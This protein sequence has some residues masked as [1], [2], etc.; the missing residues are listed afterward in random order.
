MIQS[1]P[2]T[3]R[4]DQSDATGFPVLALSGYLEETLAKK[5]FATIETLLCEGK[6]DFIIDFGGCV[7]LNSLATGILQTLTMKVEDFDG[8]LVLI[9]TTATMERVFE[10][11]SIIPSAHLAPDVA[12]AVALI[13]RLA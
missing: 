3:S 12:T 6:T 13:K 2:T 5:L 8:T 10:L 4:L 11:A 9:R 7:A 1:H